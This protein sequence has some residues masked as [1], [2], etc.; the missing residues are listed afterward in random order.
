MKILLFYSG[1]L[2]GK[3]YGGPV[4]SI[5][6]FTELLGDENDIYIVCLNHDLGETTVYQNI[7]DGWNRVGKANVLYLPESSYKQ[8][9]F[10]EICDEIQPDILY[11]S[12]IFS[13]KHTVPA[14]IMSRIKKIPLLLAPRGE[15]NNNAL[16]LKSL[17]K[18]LY[19][20][21][22]IKTHLLDKAYYQATSKEEK[23]NI[24]SALGV[25]ESCVFLLPNIPQ[26]PNKKDDYVK[27]SGSIKVCFVGRLVENKN[28][29]TAIKAVS[30]SKYKIT[31]DIYGP[32]E[33][34]DY[35]SM[36]NDLMK[37]SPENVSINYLGALSQ[38][39]IKKVYT[40][41][42]CLISPTRFENY[43]QAIAEAMLNDVPVIISQGTTPWDDVLEYHAGYLA[44]IDSI[45]SFTE[46]IDTIAK[47]D[48][49]QYA[50]LLTNLRS[51][52]QAKF[53]FNKLK[54]DYNTAFKVMIN[55]E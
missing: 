8:S 46:C 20:T 5:Y 54:S 27:I 28:L 19:L 32:S 23:G 18:G 2:P 26:L 6:N 3:K 55:G 48:S 1:Y 21:L 4:T 49:V 37:Q 22:L 33:D 53:D 7:D 41:Y 31:F 11:V 42:D 10:S 52:C 25:N 13:A 35:Y 38:D 12:S 50:S 17:K 40:L 15:L 9:R 51:Y 44:P 43:G 29:E 45:D 30:K 24:I 36:C 16:A 47:M 34:Q 39:E 14:L